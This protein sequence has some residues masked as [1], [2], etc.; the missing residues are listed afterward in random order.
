M[1]AT[2]RNEKESAAYYVDIKHDDGRI[3]PPVVFC[4]EDDSELADIL[5]KKINEH[6]DELE[7]SAIMQL[8]N[9]HLYH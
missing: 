7:F 5:A 1:K 6:P 2:V 4:D 9:S 3:L 8:L